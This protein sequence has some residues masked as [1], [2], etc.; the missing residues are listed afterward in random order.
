MSR[1][2]NLRRIIAEDFPKEDRQTVMLLGEILNSFMEQV[3][4]SYENNL[5]FE[6][7]NMQ[8]ATF[9]AQVNSD[10]DPINDASTV[11]KTQIKLDLGRRVIGVHTIQAKNQ[12]DTSNYPTANPYID[13]SQSS[14]L[15]RINKIT[16]LQTAEEYEL[17]I[18][19]VYET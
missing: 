1:L 19:I 4:D 11:I 18:I 17:T 14:G 9:K 3:I 10:G 16:G 15:L 7:T 13:F 12:D 5:N 8:V 6:N 2:D